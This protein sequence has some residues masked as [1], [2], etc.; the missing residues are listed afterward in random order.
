[1]KSI[2]VV[3]GGFIVV[4]GVFCFF[5]CWFLLSRELVHRG[6]MQYS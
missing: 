1:V 6:K 2:V 3:L 5:E 4:E